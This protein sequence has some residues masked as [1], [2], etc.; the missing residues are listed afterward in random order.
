[1]TGQGVEDH[2]TNVSGIITASFVYDGDGHRVKR[3]VRDV[4]IVYIDSLYKVQETTIRRI[5]I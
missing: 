3:T 2:L 5:R 1:M 4:T